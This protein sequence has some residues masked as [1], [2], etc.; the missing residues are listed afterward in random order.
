PVDRY[1][2]D[3]VCRELK[4]IVE[5]DGGQHLES[6]TDA[7]RDRNLSEIGYPVLRFWNNDIL[8]N[9]EGVVQTIESAI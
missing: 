4:L 2:C 3:F 5:A 9:I 1:V 7:V 8:Q 6:G